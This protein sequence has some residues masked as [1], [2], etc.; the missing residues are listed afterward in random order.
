MGSHGARSLSNL[1]MLLASIVFIFAGNFG[2]GYGATPV[3][4]SLLSR[5]DGVLDFHY[6]DRSDEIARLQSETGLRKVAIAP[7]NVAH[8]TRSYPKA[9]VATR[10]VSV[11]W[12]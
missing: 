12:F 10:P 7:A 5:Q 8:G 11:R 6:M 9:A 1:R 2:D 3:I 4:T